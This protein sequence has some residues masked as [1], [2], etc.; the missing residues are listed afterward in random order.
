MTVISLD[1]FEDE[2][3]LLVK[4]TRTLNEYFWT[5]TPSIILY[6]FEKYNLDICTY[7][8][9]DL[10]FFSSPSPLLEELDSKS[11]LL[12]EHH[13]TPYYDQAEL[14]G[15]Y[16]V[17][18]M[19]F[20]NDGRSKQVLLWWR[21]AC[22]EWCY[23]KRQNGKFGDQ[24]YLDDWPERFE[25]IHVT[26]HRGILAP[27]NI[28]QYDIKQKDINLVVK[29]KS[30]TQEYDIIFYHFHHLRFIDHRLIDL[31]GYRISHAAKKNIYYPYI[32]QLESMKW[33]YPTIDKV[34]NI[35]GVDKFPVANLKAFLRFM[36]HCLIFNIVPRKLI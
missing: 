19:T 36:K 24:K 17:Q 26:K 20:R 3:L 23:A 1:E 2:E 8:D 35:H 22:N 34:I 15:K 5:C 12:T 6:A 32:H 11:I 28:Q 30:S 16:C 14:S 4:K 10:Y 13:Y 7:L 25:G 21:S 31:G 18:F 29:S 27:W 9:A 33:R